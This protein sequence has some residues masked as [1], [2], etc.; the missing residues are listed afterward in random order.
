MGQHNRQKATPCLAAMLH[1]SVLIWDALGPRESVPLLSGLGVTR[2]TCEWR[3]TCLW[4]KA[5]AKGS[6]QYRQCWHLHASIDAQICSMILYHATL[7]NKVRQECSCP[8]RNEKRSSQVQNCM[9]LGREARSHEVPGMETSTH[10]E[11][12]LDGLV[13]A[14][15]E[16]VDELLDLGLPAPVL[17]LPPRQLSALVSERRVLVQRLAV[18][19]PA[20]QCVLLL[21][22]TLMRRVCAVSTSC[23]ADAALTKDLDQK[24]HEGTHHA[25]V[26]LGTIMADRTQA[27]Q[28]STSDEWG[29]LLGRQAVRK[30]PKGFALCPC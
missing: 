29:R 6:Q 13:L 14:Q 19:M 25:D 2:G 30:P 9:Q 20:R 17:F 11:G 28:P 18:H 26:C 5:H 24:L 27:I 8:L 15:V 3:E 16:C 4:A 10:L 22:A 23:P 12:A 7:Y 1:L 21:H